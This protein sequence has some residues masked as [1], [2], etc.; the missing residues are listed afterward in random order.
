MGK[1]CC[2]KVHNLHRRRLSTPCQLG[3]RCSNVGQ[4][5]AP[6]SEGNDWIA[7][8]LRAP[9]HF[10][11]QSTTPNHLLIPCIH[12]A[13]KFCWVV[14]Y[15]IVWGKGICGGGVDGN[16]MSGQASAISIQWLVAINKL[17]LISISVIMH[18]CSRSSASCCS[19]LNLLSAD[20]SCCEVSTMNLNT[21]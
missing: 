9:A 21:S 14:K 19:I 18:T 11:L 12:S 1:R 6:L 20:A 4:E 15:E 2:S 10:A 5:D 8:A 17:S 3:Q 7:V 13:R 16:V